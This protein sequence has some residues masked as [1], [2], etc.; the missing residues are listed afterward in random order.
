MDYRIRFH[1]Q[2]EAE[3]DQIYADIRDAAGSAI[4]G[5]YVGG[6]YDFLAGFRTFPKRGTVREG[7][8]AGLRLV[9]YRRSCTV[10]FVVEGDRVTVLAFSC[11]GAM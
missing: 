3:I 5:H 11:A 10:A 6:L 8:V 1:V 4:A 9:G 2:A 7:P